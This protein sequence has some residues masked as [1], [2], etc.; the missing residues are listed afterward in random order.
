MHPETKKKSP[1]QRFNDLTSEMTVK[2]TKIDELQEE[3]K[4]LLDEQENLL[5][6]MN[7]VLEEI[8]SN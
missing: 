8:K 7:K 2:R 5:E 1:G 4:Q 6:E 3:V